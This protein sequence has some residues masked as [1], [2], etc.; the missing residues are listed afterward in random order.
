MKILITGSGG[1]VGGSIGRFAARAGHEVLGLA[2]RSQRDADWPGRHV[3][4][5]VA[6]SDL[7]EVIRD[8]SPQV[9]FHGAGTAS[10]GSSLSAPLDDLRASAM[11][12]ANVLDSTRRSG[13]RPLLVFPSSAAVYGNPAAL[14][15]AESSEIA[16]ISPY[17]FHKMACEL[18]GREYAT[19][20]GLSIVICRIFSL[21]GPA[22]RRLLVWELFEQLIGPEPTVWLQG[23]GDESRDFLHIHDLSSAVM[24]L[25]GTRTMQNQPDFTVVNVAAGREVNAVDL[26]KQLRDLV[27][28]DKD[29][30]CRG[31]ARRGDPKRWAADI[32]L[33]ARMAPNWQSAPLLDSLGQ[34][35]SDWRRA[36]KS[37]AR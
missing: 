32:N 15:V 5:D 12:W 23:N 24:E 1:F 3:A 19:C 13:T 34:C 4:V 30:R 6:Q 37:V 8:F 11:T 26:A 14:P 21:F 16:P 28:V 20:Y 9:I 31:I 22:Q 10:V 2:R 25:V 33:L 36:Q 27:G 17:G 7:V 35:V 18:I 29:I